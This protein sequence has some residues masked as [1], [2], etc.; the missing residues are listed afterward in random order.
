LATLC[1]CG[2]VNRIKIQGDEGGETEHTG[3]VW[4]CVLPAGYVGS[5]F[6]GGCLIV[7]AGS[8]LG[9]LIA[10][11]VLVL[12]LL[13]TLVLWARSPWAIGLS[14]FGI[15]IIGAST[16][17]FWVDVDPRAYGPRIVSGLA[18]VLNCLFACYDIVD[19]LIKRTVEDSDSAKCSEHCSCVSSSR[20]IGVCWFMYAC[21]FF[22]VAVAVCVVIIVP[23]DPTGKELPVLPM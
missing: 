2:H 1:T 9:S 16:I 22:L 15:L 13:V 11:L 20:C 17:P 23:I 19:D 12:L 3:G 21:T 10:C 4:W 7:A 6:L 18:G 8:P 5:A 14:L